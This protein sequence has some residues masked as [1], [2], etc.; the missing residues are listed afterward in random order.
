MPNWK[1]L[2]PG[3]SE[4]IIMMVIL[5]LCMIF[6]NGKFERLTE[7]IS[8]FLTSSYAVLLAVVILVE[9]LILKGADRSAHYRLELRAA[10]AKRRDDIL[11]LREIETE[12]LALRSRLDPALP[13]APA[14]GG[15]DAAQ[16]TEKILKTLRSRI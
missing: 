3:S 15:E 5:L 1:K 2:K 9:Y 4:I 13:N 14:E 8:G 11:A 10:R 16:I 6:V 7:I 12:L